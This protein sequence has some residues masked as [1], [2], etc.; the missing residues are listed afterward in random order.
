LKSHLKR[1]DCENIEDLVEQIGVI[2]VEQYENIFRGAY[3][4]CEYIAKSDKRHRV[5]KKKYLEK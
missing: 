1:R 5:L 4:R 2:P 3:Q